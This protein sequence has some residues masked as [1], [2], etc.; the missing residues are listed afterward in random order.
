MMPLHGSLTG[1][2][3]V[4]ALQRVEHCLLCINT[5]CATAASQTCDCIDSVDIRHKRC[6]IC[7]QDVCSPVRRLERE[8]MVG[9]LEDIGPVDGRSNLQCM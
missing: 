9:S 5:V 6:S 4:H 7:I 2:Y 8:A 3:Q 1:N